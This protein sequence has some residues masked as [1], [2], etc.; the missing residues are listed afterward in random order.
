MS[1]DSDTL[2]ATV[3]EA[4]AGTRLDLVALELLPAEVSRSRLGTWIRDG[5]LRVDGKVVATPGELVAEGQELALTP[6]RQQLVEPGSPLDPGILYEDEALAILDK[7]AGLVM[8]GTSAGDPQPSVASWL[9]QRYGSKLPIA[10]GANRPGVVHRLDRD[11]SG[12]CV[13]AFQ[14]RVFEDLMQQFA[15]RS[16]AKEYRA[17]VYGEPRFESDWI[18]KRLMSDPRRPNRVRITRSWDAG[19]RDAAT[20]WQVIERFHGYAALRLRPKTGRK[21]QIRA[22]LRS[23]DHPIVGDPIYRAKNYGL[24]MLPDGHPEVQRTLLHA[25]AL[26]FEHPVSGET[27]TF[28][29]DPPPDFEGL[30]RF[31]REKL[32]PR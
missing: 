28:R 7:P 13:V 26:R 29:S 10:Q 17:L 25:Y 21:H 9:V 27:V 19:T 22:H 11:T 24:G 1:D 23:I 16:V 3:P 31:L 20:F 18:E 8:H 14:P 5:R 32:P 12:V 15:D 4:L 2:R 30:A 6:P